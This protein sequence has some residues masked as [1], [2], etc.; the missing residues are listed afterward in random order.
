[1]DKTSVVTGKVRLSYAHIWEPTSMNETTDKKY[2][3]N[4]LIAKT[5][6]VTLAKVRAAIAAAL[7]HGQGQNAG[8]ASLQKKGKVLIEK[9]LDMPLMD[10]DEEGSAVY[11]GHF[12]LRAKNANQPGIVSTEKD[13]KGEWIPIT[14][15]TKVYSGCFCRA[16]INFYPGGLAVGNPGVFCS[17]K[18]LQKLSDGEPLSGGYSNP[19]DD[20]EDDLDAFEDEGSENTDE[21]SD[22]DLL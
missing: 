13:A 5:D 21:N 19:N 4:L 10:G 14:D 7:E 20:F 12:Y 16:S 17:L 18:N 2:Q 11:K 15:K 6:T 9:D 8:K 1:M 3:V 22:D